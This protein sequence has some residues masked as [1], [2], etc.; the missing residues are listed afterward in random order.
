MELREYVPTDEVVSEF[1][2]WLAD[3]GAADVITL[4]GSGEPTM[5]SRFG[6]IIDAIKSACSIPVVL[7]TNGSLLH[8]PEVRAAAA[9]ADIVKGSLSAWDSDSFQRVN[10]PVPGLELEQIVDGLQAFR[11]TFTGELLLEVFLLKGVNDDPADVA[12]I[13]ALAETIKPD[14]V[15]LNTVVRP[16]A[17]ASAEHVTRGDLEH[18]APLFTPA[19]EIIAGFRAGEEGEGS[20]AI[21]ERHVLA[22]ITRR[23][24]TVDDIAGAF[25]V[26]PEDAM[27]FVNALLAAG[28]ARPFERPDGVYYGS[29]RSGPF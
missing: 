2:Q 14:R 16:P 13:A 3:G 11:G 28:S 17:E 9:K 6:E 18:L 29:T 22:M 26:L 1:R 20:A 24:C 21:D 23:P 15:Q 19:A 12:R 27:G 7:L 8:L 4:A 25:S 10:R 5:H